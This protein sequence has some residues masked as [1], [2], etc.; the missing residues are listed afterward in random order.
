MAE[1]LPAHD[2][3][4]NNLST[5][6]IWVDNLSKHTSLAGVVL[7]RTMVRGQAALTPVP[8]NGSGAMFDDRQAGQ[9]D[10]AHQGRHPAFQQAQRV[11]QSVWNQ[12]NRQHQP[13]PSLATTA[14]SLV[15]TVGGQA[16][17]TG[18]RATGEVDRSWVWVDGTGVW[19]ADHRGDGL[20]SR[21]KH[22]AASAWAPV[23]ADRQ[24]PVEAER[25]G[26]QAM[27]IRRRG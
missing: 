3:V 9:H 27:A 18:T 15:Q 5:T 6:S 17:V 25:D 26:G 23:L 11:E 21:S 14:L 16:T 13:R 22:N 4:I 7:E 24:A 19:P 12:N 8:A 10:R 2:I 20:I 1:R